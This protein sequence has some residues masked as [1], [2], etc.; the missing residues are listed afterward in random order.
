MPLDPLPVIQECSESKDASALSP[1]SILSTTQEEN[2][3]FTANI[4]GKGMG[5]VASSDIAPGQLIMEEGPLFSVAL[6]PSGDLP[7]KVL[8]KPKQP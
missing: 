8:L 7:G 6:T 4:V 3:Y 1:S 5:V 2:V